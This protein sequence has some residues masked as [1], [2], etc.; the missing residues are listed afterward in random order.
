MRVDIYVDGSFNPVSQQ[1]GSGIVILQDGEK[2]QEFSVKGTEDYFNKYHN[3][4]GEVFATMLATRWVQDNIKDTHDVHLYYDYEGIEKWPDGR[5]TANNML[6]QSYRSHIQGLPYKIKFH[7]VRAHT[8]D[9]MN[10]LADKLAR[11]AV[12]L[13]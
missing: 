2:A 10:E 1:Y 7:K 6:S 5:W 11:R 4:A 13:S 9:P 3:V 12:G 8:G